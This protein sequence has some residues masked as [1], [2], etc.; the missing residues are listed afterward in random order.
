[1]IILTITIILVIIFSIR[2]KRRRE[3]R[4]AK[5]GTE[6]EL[7]VSN[8]LSQLPDEYITLNNVILKTPRGTTQIDHIVVSKHGVFVIETKNYRGNIYGND[9]QKEWKQL[10]V[11]PVTFD[12]N[13]WKTYTYVTK[14]YFYNPVKQSLG[15][16]YAVKD[17]LKDF[18]H[19]PIVPIV[20]FAGEA[21][22]RYV[23]SKHHVILGDD[24]VN[25]ITQYQSLFL[26]DNGLSKVLSIL[27]E[28]DQSE[29]ITTKEHVDNI[30]KAH[31]ESLDKVREGICP[32][33]G[34]ELVLRSGPY[35]SF[36]GCSNYPKCKF[37]KKK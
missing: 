28:K 17:E 23:H 31:F 18:P 22:I 27:R 30:R 37:I 7:C 5:I 2:A 11:T 8:I 29:I 9:D 33:C 25:T 32:W 1:M 10:I 15:H 19:L 16:M 6:G 20:V 35:E 4:P 3:Q 34:G 14:N 36:Y 13:W 26:S 12:N 21:N 24:L